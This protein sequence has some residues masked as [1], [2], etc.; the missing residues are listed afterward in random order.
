MIKLPWITGKKKNQAAGKAP[1]PSPLPED[2]PGDATP[3]RQ[4]L[5]RQALATH[6]T[7]ADV[8]DNLS[9][10]EREKLYVIALKTLMPDEK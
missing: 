8:F 6:R 3:E 4:E 2:M 5:I 9:K 10:E 1:V 7:K